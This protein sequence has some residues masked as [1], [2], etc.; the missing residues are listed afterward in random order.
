MAGEKI[1][2]LAQLAEQIAQL[3]VRLGCGLLVR[4][5]SSRESTSVTLST[6]KSNLRPA[7]TLYAAAILNPRFEEKE[8]NRVHKLHLQRL[9][10]LQDR[11]TY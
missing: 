2:A 10:Q 7:M 8:W 1:G 4:A 9:V 11:P 6:L 3:C 5:G